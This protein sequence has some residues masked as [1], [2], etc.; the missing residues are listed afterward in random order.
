MT[1]TAKPFGLKPSTW[2]SLSIAILLTCGFVI[3]YSIAVML[4][5]VTIQGTPEAPVDIIDFDIFYLVGQMFWDGNLSQAYDFKALHAEQV[6]R[7]GATDLMTWSYPPQFDLVVAVLG[8][9][10][11]ALSYLLFVS[12]SLVGYIH[13]MRR[14]A[15]GYSGAVLVAIAP[16][17]FI[18]ARN[19]QNGL[20]TGALIGMFCLLFL[21]R[22][23]LAGLPL[24][25]MI[26]KPHLAVGISVLSLV[27]WSWK[28]MAVGAAVV[29]ASVLAATM[30]FGP[31]IWQTFLDGAAQASAFMWEGY[32]PAFYMTSVFAMLTTL[33]VSPDTAMAA[34]VAVALLAVAAIVVAW[35]AG[36]TRKTLAGVAVLASVIISPYNYGYDLPILGIALALLFP[37]IDR[38]GATLEKALLFGLAWTATGWGAMRNSMRLWQSDTPV[39]DGPDPVPSLAGLAMLLLVLLVFNIVRRDFAGRANGQPRPGMASRGG[40]VSQFSISSTAS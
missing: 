34:Q 8:L 35:K 16:S 38:S 17:L 12:L 5:I 37:V 19:G 30:A 14:L 4:G 1:E 29:A 27:T 3:S 20:L 2:K 23:S 31:G 36:V 40:A 6:A 10:P 32:F 39:I 26:I 18:V 28:T 25:L 13:V 7:T 22:R 24:G 11:Q 33:G 21:Q 15:G 9:L